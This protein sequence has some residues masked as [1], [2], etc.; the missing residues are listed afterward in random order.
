TDCDLQL[1]V[2]HLYT[3]QSQEALTPT[4]AQEFVLRSGTAYLALINRST[5][6][7][8]VAGKVYTNVVDD[9]A[10]PS[11]ALKINEGTTLKAFITSAEFYDSN[12][13]STEPYAVPAGSIV[14]TG[15]LITPP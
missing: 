10:I 5:G 4:A 12:I 1:Y 11:P 14:L 13:E 15:D 7:M 8:R 6:D 9:F 2:G 3:E